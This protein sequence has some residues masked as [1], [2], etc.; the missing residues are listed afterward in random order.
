MTE[1]DQYKLF[2]KLVKFIP[3]KYKKRKYITTF[4]KITNYLDD[5]L[6]DKIG[7]IP[8]IDVKYLDKNKKYIWP[9]CKICEKKLTFIFQISTLIKKNIQLFMCMRCNKRKYPDKTVCIRPINYDNCIKI[10]KSLLH[11]NIDSSDQINAI[12]KYS[13]NYYGNRTPIDSTTYGESELY[14]FMDEKNHY[15]L[16]NWKT[17]KKNRQLQCYKIDKYIKRTDINCNYNLGKL[18][19]KY[20]HA[21]IKNK[22]SDWIC[23]CNINHY[24]SKK[25]N[26]SIMDNL[27]K[28]KAYNILDKRYNFTKTKKHRNKGSYLCECFG[29][30]FHEYVLNDEDDEFIKIGGIGITENNRTHNSL[31]SFSESEYIPHQWGESGGANILENM[32]FIVD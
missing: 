28:K 29:D 24:Y 10:K 32:S 3:D 15:K 31:V 26:V 30:M 6:F 27:E 11:F 2:N 18:I 5:D 17:D 14:K 23:T 4:K 25:N 16:I 13:Y 20:E 12:Y 21:R 7:G 19:N 22:I 8:S 9:A 1:T